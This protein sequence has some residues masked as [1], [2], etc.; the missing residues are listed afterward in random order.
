VINRNK[1]LRIFGVDVRRWAARYG[2][3]PFSH[4]CSKCGKVLTTSI[5]FVCGSLRGLVAP[6]CKCGHTGT[7]YCVARD[8]KVGDLFAGD[9]QG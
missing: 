5:P 4:P 8:P 6:T 2:L 7:P 3:E 1:C 9:L